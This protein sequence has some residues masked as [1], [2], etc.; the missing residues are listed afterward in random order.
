MDTAE[1]GFPIQPICIVCNMAHMENH[2]PGYFKYEFGIKGVPIKTCE[3]RL[4]P[5]ND[6]ELK[7]RYVHK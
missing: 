6:V 1:Y 7:L 5:K 2:S 4:I 3:G